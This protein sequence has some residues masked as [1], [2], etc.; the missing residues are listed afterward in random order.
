MRRRLEHLP[1]QRGSLDDDPTSPD[2]EV[3]D[4]DDAEAFIRELVPVGPA[5]DNDHWID[6]LDSSVPR[7]IYRGQANADWHLTPAAFRPNVLRL[8]LEEC[9]LRA[10]DAIPGVPASRHAELRAVLAFVRQCRRASIPVPED[11]Q[12]LRGVEEGCWQDLFAGGEQFP[13]KPL[14][15]LFALAQHHGVPTRLLDWTTS[16]FTAAYFAAQGAAAAQQSG[17]IALWALLVPN[18]RSWGAILYPQIELVGAPHDANEFL[19]AQEGVF[20]VVQSVRPGYTPDVEAIHT[21]EAISYA[22]W[23]APGMG[24]PQTDPWVKKYTLPVAEARRAL[25]LLDRLNVSAATIFPGP[26]GAVRALRERQFWR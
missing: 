24:S 7:W 25:R 13:P 23:Y 6:E 8:F 19:R 14:L 9:G 3:I 12:I 5:W 15:S 10:D 4:F 16:P 11:S 18:V 20:T 1:N 17:R 2:V 21:E 22:W 26:G